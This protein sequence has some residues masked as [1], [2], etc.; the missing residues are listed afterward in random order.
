MTTR[1]LHKRIGAALLAAFVLIPAAPALAALPQQ[2]AAF[3]LAATPPN[4][5]LHAGA[6][7]EQAGTR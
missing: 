7:G 1:T 3:D 2:S 5:I 4:P 6:T